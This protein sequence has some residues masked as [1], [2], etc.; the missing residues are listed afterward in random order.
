MFK[1]LA[2]DLDAK[3][4]CCKSDQLRKILIHRIKAMNEF[5]TLVEGSGPAYRSIG[6]P[7]NLVE[8]RSPLS[9]LLE[10]GL[11]RG[12]AIPKSMEGSV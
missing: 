12:A 7:F 10:Q 6:I 5:I 1:L 9:K 11:H 3:L 4:P 2:T 8:D